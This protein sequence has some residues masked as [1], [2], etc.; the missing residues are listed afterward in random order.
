[1]I[2]RPALTQPSCRSVRIISELWMGKTRSKV[3]WPPLY[4][5][6][7]YSKCRY[8]RWPK[9]LQMLPTVSD[10]RGAVNY[11]YTIIVSLLA[12]VVAVKSRILATFI[13][14][15]PIFCFSV[16]RGH[17]WGRPQSRPLRNGLA[18]ITLE[19]GGGCWVI[20]TA[21][22]Y[23]RQA[24]LGPSVKILRF[25]SLWAKRR[26]WTLIVNC[27]LAALMFSE[28]SFE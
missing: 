22:N 20:F 26:L 1:M 18:E 4:R 6:L 8:C 12:V 11:F 15:I 13:S 10:A 3:F 7:W 25:R 14:R 17:R 9:Y 27:F 19:W 16:L 23:P 21:I 5:H 24:Q 28:R 2:S